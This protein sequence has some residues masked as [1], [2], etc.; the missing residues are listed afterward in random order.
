MVSTKTRPFSIFLLKKGYDTSNS[1]KDN[2][3][4]S[5]AV[6][7][8]KLPKH[9]TLFVLDNPPRDPWWKNYF[10]IEQP[11]PQASKGALV[12]IPVKDRCFALSFG[13]VFHNLLDNCYEYDF[14]LRVTLNSLDPNKLKSVR[15]CMEL[16]TYLHST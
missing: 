9:S 1:L 2:N 12:F 16:T 13:H 6:A 8:K 10:D 11:L 15:N 5:K 7:A 4:L 14:G 3:S